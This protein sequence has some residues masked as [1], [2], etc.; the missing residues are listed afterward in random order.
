MQRPLSRRAPPLGT[1]DTPPAPLLG[2]AGN[3]QAPTRRGLQPGQG[4]PR[5]PTPAA[6]SS[7]AF[8]GSG[9]GTSSVLTLLTTSMRDRFPQIERSGS[10]EGLADADRLVATEGGFE[11]VGD[12]VPLPEKRVA[13][14]A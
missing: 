10:T 3:R 12:A 7:S 11:A 13:G 14:E 1:R 8:L 9:A 2:Q 4:A 5:G 6:G